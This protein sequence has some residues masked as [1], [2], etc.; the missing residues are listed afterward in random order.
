MCTQGRS[1]ATAIDT[2]TGEFLKERLVPNNDVV[3]E[4]LRG[5]PAPVAVTYKAGP[6]GF[7]L[8]RAITATGLRCVVT[9]PSKLVRPSGVGSRPAP[10]TRSCWPGCCATTTSRRSGCRAAVEIGDWHRYTGASI[11]AYLR[12]VPS[13]HPT[14]GSR[15]LGAIT[16]TGNSHVRRLLIESA[17]HHRPIIA[18]DQHCGHGGNWHPKPPACVPIP[19][20][21]AFITA[22]CP[23]PSGTRLTPW[24]PPR[25]RANSPAGAGHWPRWSETQPLTWTREPTAEQRE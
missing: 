8:S 3:V 24:P 25:L 2:M 19:A 1:S 12:L 4:W 11:G 16:K 18:S 22:W 21:S 7:G 13:E 14:G 5:L 15:R 23:T 10:G 6:T 9:T 20:T 17:W